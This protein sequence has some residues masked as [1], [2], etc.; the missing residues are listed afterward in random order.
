MT[1]AAHHLSGRRIYMSSGCNKTYSQKK[2]EQAI[3]KA[4]ERA[5][6]A[7]LAEGKDIRDSAW[8]AFRTPPYG[9]RTSEPDW[10]ALDRLMK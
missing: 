10:D 2:R 1:Q 5:G 8:E 9:K 3:R 6:L 4:Q 7:K